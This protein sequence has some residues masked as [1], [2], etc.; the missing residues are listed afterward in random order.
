M[1]RDDTRQTIKF[2]I[3]TIV[4][5]IIL[6]IA[7][8]FVFFRAGTQSRDNDKQITQLA[9][10]K[11]PIRNVQTYYHLDRGT[12]SYSLE[13][14][15]KKGQTYYFIYLPKTKKAY[16]YPAKKGVSRNRIKSEFKRLHPKQSISEVNLGWY[17]GEA[18][19]EITSQNKNNDYSYSLYEFKSGNEISEVANL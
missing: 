8:V 2:I 12:N 7:S 5:I 4:V 13:G 11:T 14:T 10:Q 1:I 9:M 19:W 15:N 17:Q 16:L 18:V 3:W 6:Y